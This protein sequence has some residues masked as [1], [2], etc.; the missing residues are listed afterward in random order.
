[1][2]FYELMLIFSPALTED[3]EKDQLNQIEETLKK[4][5]ASI[6]LMDHWGKRKLAYPVKKQRQ[7]YY[8]WLYVE[9]EPGR[10]A[11]VDRKLKMVEPLLRFM[12]LKMERVQIDNLHKEIARRSEVRQAEQQTAEQS[13]APE[14]VEQQPAVEETAEAESSKSDGAE[15]VGG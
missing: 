10:I 8:E 6:H 7:G 4:E 3:E 5:R 9:G 2:N 11:E 12:I 13:V 1:M 14:A 15:E